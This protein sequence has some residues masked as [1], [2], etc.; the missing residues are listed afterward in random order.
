MITNEQIR[1][2]IG[3][4]RVSDHAIALIIELGASEQELL[5]AQSRMIRGNVVGTESRRPASSAV[6]RLC[7]ILSADENNFPGEAVE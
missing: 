1:E 5:E 3:H 2:I 4:S 6:L 7:E